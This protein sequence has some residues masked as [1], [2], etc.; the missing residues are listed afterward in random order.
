MMYKAQKTLF[1]LVFEIIAIYLVSTNKNDLPLD[2]MAEIL[3]TLFGLVFLLPQIIGQ[4]VLRPH[5]HN[6]DE[7]Y[8]K[9]LYFIAFFFGLGIAIPICR[10]AFYRQ[11]SL[12][13]LSVPLTLHSVSLF[14][15]LNCLMLL[16]LFFNSIIG[17]LSFVRNLKTLKEKYILLMVYTHKRGCNSWLQFIK[18]IPRYIIGRFL[19]YTWGDV[20]SHM[21]KISSAIESLPV[22]DECYMTGCI[23][24]IFQILECLLSN[25]KSEYYGGLLDEMIRNSSISE[26]YTLKKATIDGLNDMNLKI[27]HSNWFLEEKDK[28]KETIK[29]SIKGIAKIV[30]S[31]SE[32]NYDILILEA[33]ENLK[34]IYDKFLDKKIDEFDYTVFVY[35]LQ[36]LCYKSFDNDIRGGVQECI[37]NLYH[38]AVSFKNEKLSISPITMAIENIKDT[39]NECAEKRW[40]NLYFQ[41]LIRLLQLKAELPENYHNIILFCSLIMASFCNKYMPEARSKVEE[42]LNK[43]IGDSKKIGEPALKY[44]RGYSQIQYSVLKKYLET[45]DEPE[46]L[47]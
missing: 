36:E 39:G 29:K 21:N 10:I 24:D 25:Q 9:K 12:L 6:P 5:S 2:T 42:I 22:I 14:L 46:R 26:S 17:N 40:E 27:I 41:S 18:E 11:L 4:F 35:S 31:K 13:G 37:R 23:G 34:I 45:L 8:P 30:S 7:I 33:Q 3:A 32:F 43:Q 20:Q 16:I 19:E 38:I 15:F 44:A 47:T 1:V 28:G